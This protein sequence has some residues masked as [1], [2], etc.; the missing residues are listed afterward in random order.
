MYL[1]KLKADFKAMDADGNGV[2]TKEDLL[3]KAKEVH[4]YLS[5]EELESTIQSMDENDDG[6]ISLEEFIAATVSRDTTSPT[7][8]KP[9]VLWVTT[10]V[11]I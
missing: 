10:L 6:K 11:N 4:Y 5:E 3:Q 2:V 9:H 7:T 8:V 1:E